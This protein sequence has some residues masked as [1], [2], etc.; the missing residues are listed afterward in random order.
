MCCHGGKCPGGSCP[1]GNC[2]E[3]IVRVVV[4]LG[5]IVLGGNCPRRVIVLGCNCPRRVIVLGGNFPG[6][7]CPGGSYPGVIVQGVVVLES[8]NIAYFLTVKEKYYTRFFY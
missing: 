3:V 1:G 6:G 2:P 8:A 5:V 7:D 4:N